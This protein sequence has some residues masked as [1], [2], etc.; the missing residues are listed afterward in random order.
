MAA[1][2]VLAKAIDDLLQPPRTQ[3]LEF[4][5]DNGRRCW[6]SRLPANL[7]SIPGGPPRCDLR[8]ASLSLAQAACSERPECGGVTRDNGL[9]CKRDSGMYNIYLRFELRSNLTML[10]SLL[11]G[12]SLSGSSWLSLRPITR[13]N[14]TMACSARRLRENLRRVYLKQLQLQQQQAQ[15]KMAVQLALQRETRAKLQRMQPQRRGSPHVLGIAALP[16]PSERPPVRRGAQSAANS[17]D[18]L[19]QYARVARFEPLPAAAAL[20]ACGCERRKQS[21]RNSRE[22]VDGGGACFGSRLAREPLDGS[23]NPFSWQ[24]GAHDVPGGA[25]RALE[26]ARVRIE[27]RKGAI[28]SAVD[29]AVRS[30]A[31]LP[32]GNPMPLCALLRRRAQE[33]TS[34]NFSSTDGLNERSL[35]ALGVA[36]ALVYRS[37]LRPWQ[38]TESVAVRRR[39]ARGSGGSGSTGG[40][41]GSGSSGSSSKGVRGERSRDPSGQILAVEEA[42]HDYTCDGGLPMM[43]NNLGEYAIARTAAQSGNL[44]FL[45]VRRMCPWEDINDIQ[46]LLPAVAPAPRPNEPPDYAAAVRVACAHAYHGGTHVSSHV[47]GDVMPRLRQ[48]MRA[49][50]SAWAQHAGFPPPGEPL[51]DVAIHMRCGDAMETRHSAY[52]LLTV[53]SVA[54]AIPLNRTMTV[55]IVTQPFERSC[56]HIG[57]AVAAGQLLPPPANETQNSTARG[58]RDSAGGTMHGVRNCACSCAVVLRHYVEALQAL[59]PMATV[60]VR[61]RDARVGALVRLTFAP[62]ASICQPSSFCIWPAMAAT[63]R[64]YVAHTAFFP[65]RQSEASLLDSLPALRVMDRSSVVHYATLGGASSEFMRMMAVKKE[66]GICADPRALKD[67]IKK[68]MPTPL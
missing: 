15:Q 55:G 45:L 39:A 36:H 61:D 33:H 30:Q 57:L 66:M 28:P 23:L 1:N 54:A 14:G 62:H 2:G 21:S 43:G 60:T 38:L 26:V 50:L 29:D 52:G 3:P 51:D 41:G 67:W 44:P 32:A 64:G 68:L 13:A 35:R 49:G 53:E 10:D 46:P 24:H 17:T 40:S 59:R 65:S 16:I 20:D 6:S 9:R 34:H 5:L 48:E 25:L 19:K 8:F 12:G 18:C 63:R 31:C 37:H 47:W 58:Q 11:L 27:A 22:E 4:A 56:P 7:A 42:C